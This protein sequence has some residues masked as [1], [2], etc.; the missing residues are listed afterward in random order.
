MN[1]L[2]SVQNLPCLSKL[3]PV[4]KT[5]LPKIEQG[6]ELMSGWGVKMATIWGCYKAL[7]REITQNGLENFVEGAIPG[8]NPPEFYQVIWT[9]IANCISSIPGDTFLLVPLGDYDKSEVLME[10]L[11]KLESHFVPL[12]TQFQVLLNNNAKQKFESAIQNANLSNSPSQQAGQ[13]SEDLELNAIIAEPDFPFAFINIGYQ[14]LEYFTTG[15]GLRG[16]KRDVNGLAQEPEINQE[17]TDYEGIFVD[18]QRINEQFRN[19]LTLSLEIQ[20]TYPGDENHPSKI[21][22]WFKKNTPEIGSNFYDLDFATSMGF[23]NKFIDYIKHNENLFDQLIKSSPLCK[24]PDDFIYFNPMSEKI[25]YPRCL[26]L[27]I[28]VENREQ[29]KAWHSLCKLAQFTVADLSSNPNSGYIP[30]DGT[31]PLHTLLQ[32][33]HQFHLNFLLI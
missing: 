2:A 6:T 28:D 15:M 27:A 33:R 26:E 31:Q 1:G 18:I 12:I 21:A 25:E 14:E 29:F 10:L 5:E 7:S 20:N 32:K 17:L 13:V 30:T 4:L 19:L 9:N 16:E 11:K 24:N 22:D 23:I 3:I 8:T